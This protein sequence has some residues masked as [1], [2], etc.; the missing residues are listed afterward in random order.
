MKH[1]DAARRQRSATENPLCGAWFHGRRIVAERGIAF[2]EIAPVAGVLGIRAAHQVE[3]PDLCGTS[4][5][6]LGLDG[7]IA[8]LERLFVGRVWSME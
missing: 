3:H 5:G 2:H 8:F 6:G 1:A 7:D 4:T